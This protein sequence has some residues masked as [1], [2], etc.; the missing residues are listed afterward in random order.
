MAQ[1]EAKHF[2]VL[3]NGKLTNRI[4]AIIEHYRG[5]GVNVELVLERELNRLNDKLLISN[6]LK[7]EEDETG[8]IAEKFHLEP[9]SYTN[10]KI[11][12]IKE[13]LSVLNS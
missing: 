13:I 10:A 1:T 12:A 5:L 11:Q 4:S 8:M 3:K 9:A 6:I 2:T 7:P